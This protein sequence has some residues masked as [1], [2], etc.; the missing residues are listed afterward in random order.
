M[1][2]A[3]DDKKS[4]H[5]LQESLSDYD[6]I[7][8]PIDIMKDIERLEKQMYL[9]AQNLEFEEAIKLRNRVKRLEEQLKK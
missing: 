7:K 6:I 9:H 1:E 8:D 4:K 2:G 3:Y 5:Q